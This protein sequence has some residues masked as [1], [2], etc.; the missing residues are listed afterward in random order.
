MMVSIFLFHTYPVVFGLAKILQSHCDCLGCGSWAVNSSCQPSVDSVRK[1]SINYC[2]AWLNC[3]SHSNRNE[4]GRFCNCVQ[5]QPRWLCR[6]SRTVNE[7]PLRLN[8][9]VT[10]TMFIVLSFMAK[11][12]WEFTWVTW[13]N[14]DWHQVAAKTW[15]LSSLVLYCH[16]PDIH[17]SPCVLLLSHKA[18]THFAVPWRVEGWVNLGTELLQHVFSPWTSCAT[19]KRANH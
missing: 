19:V 8:N 11:P 10:R 13:M 16:R 5:T 2:S 6:W 4:S 17:P 9:I 1:W 15:P 7:M 14:V 18:D 3:H 12:L